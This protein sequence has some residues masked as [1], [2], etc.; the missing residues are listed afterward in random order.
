MIPHIGKILY[1]INNYSVILS[2]KENICKL[3]YTPP[4]LTCQ[5]HNVGK[6][7]YSYVYFEVNECSENKTS[8]NFHYSEQKNEHNI[9]QI[10]N[11]TSLYDIF[12]DSKNN[13]DIY[14]DRKSITGRI[15]GF[16]ITDNQLSSKEMSLLQF[17]LI[18]RQKNILNDELKQ[19]SSKLDSAV[20]IV[21]RTDIKKILSLIQI[22]I[23]ESFFSNPGKDDRY[24]VTRIVSLDNS[25]NGKIDQWLYS[26]FLKIGSSQV[27]SDSG[28]CSCYSMRIDNLVTG[29]L[30]GHNLQEEICDLEKRYNRKEHLKGLIHKLSISMQNLYSSLLDCELL[31]KE[32]STFITPIKVKMANDYC[33]YDLKVA[34]SDNPITFE[35]V[36]KDVLFRQN[37]QFVIQHFEV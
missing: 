4:E 26:D 14:L 30:K 7:K 13:I 19:T 5:L 25:L 18:E 34:S 12:S 24:S 35:S 11:I 2:Y 27:Y 28:Y 1:T 36:L 22:E 9:I 17:L 10:S 37:R 32:Y 15:N 8:N 29:V 20:D 23:K 21:E 31:L 3:Y 16:D 33:L 6:Q